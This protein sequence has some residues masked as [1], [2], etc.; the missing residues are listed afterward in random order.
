[1]KRTE[2]AENNA[3]ASDMVRQFAITWY[4]DDEAAKLVKT[5]GE[6][7]DEGK[8]EGTENRST[9]MLYDEALN[10]ALAKA[11]DYLAPFFRYDLDELYAVPWDGEADGGEDQDP[12]TVCADRKA[13]TEEEE[14]EKGYYYGLSAYLPTEPT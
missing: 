3:K 7:E 1:M 5:N 14:A 12:D 6:E 13:G 11:Y 10:A 9:E 8:K 4:L 2:Y